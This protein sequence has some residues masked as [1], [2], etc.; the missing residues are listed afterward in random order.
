MAVRTGESTDEQTN[1]VTIRM[2]GETDPIAIDQHATTEPAV[3]VDVREAGHR[4]SHLHSA[5][6]ASRKM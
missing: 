5:K 6:Y 4:P 3:S 2:A 1:L